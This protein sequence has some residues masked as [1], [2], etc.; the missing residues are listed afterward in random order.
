[1]DVESIECKIN[2]DLQ[3]V[4]FAFYLNIDG[5]NVEQQWYGNQSYAIF[6]LDY[7]RTKLHTVVFFVKDHAG[8]I[9]T[10]RTNLDQLEIDFIPSFNICKNKLNCSVKSTQE[11]LEFAFYLYLNDE[12]VRQRWYSENDRAEFQIDKTPIE[13]F[14]IKYFIRDG[15]SRVYSRSIIYDKFEP[16]ANP[17]KSKNQYNFFI[18]TDKKVIYKSINSSNHEFSKLLAKPGKIERFTKILNGG[19]FLSQLSDHIVKGF[20]LES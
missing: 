20:D 13:K 15:E 19:L 17:V 16:E 12:K 2:C 14:E 3:G 10:K 4:E 8:E 5:E 9:H 18:S 11:N 7:D 6:D 1:M